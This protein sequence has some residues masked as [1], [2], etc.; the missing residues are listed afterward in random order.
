VLSPGEFVDVP[1]IVCLKNTN[2]F[3]LL[4]D[5]LGVVDDD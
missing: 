3:T 5:V 1:F 2:R 4:V